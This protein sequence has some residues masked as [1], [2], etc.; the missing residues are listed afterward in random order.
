MT[1]I[2]SLTTSQLNRIIAIK[3][4]IEALQGQIESIAGGG[5]E[6]QIP[7]AEEAT[8]PARRK[9]HMTAAHKRKLIKAL[10]RAREMLGKG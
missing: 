3:Q 2:T 9:Y 1:N 6:M 8:A 10:V 5:G 7:S 4:K